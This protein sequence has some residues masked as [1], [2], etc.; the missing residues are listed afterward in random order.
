MEIIRKK[1][2]L[3][4]NK[5]HINSGLPYIPCNKEYTEILSC[6]TEPITIAEWMHDSIFEKEV[7]ESNY[8]NFQCDI[9]EN[10]P[11]FSAITCFTDSLTTVDENE[12][13]YTLYIRSTNLFRRYNQL[14]SIL[15]EGLHLKH[16]KN[17]S[18]KDVGNYTDTYLSNFTYNGVSGDTTYGFLR[19]AVPV[20]IFDKDGEQQFINMGNGVYLGPVVEGSYVI[21]LDNYEEFITLGGKE[22]IDI[23]D[24]LL[25]NQY[26]GTS[27]DDEIDNY[28]APYMSI[29][30]LL[31]SCED[32]LGIMTP[33]RDENEF[34]FS[35]ELSYDVANKYNSDT[36]GGSLYD[37]DRIYNG[38]IEDNINLSWKLRPR[39]INELSALT[40]DV[41]VESQLQ[42][43]RVSKYYVSDDNEI[44]PGL[45]IENTNPFF[46]CTYCAASGE[47]PARWEAVSTGSTGLVC[48][49][50]EDIVWGETGKYQTMTVISSL[51]KYENVPNNSG[52]TF[53]VKYNNSEETP[54]TIPYVVGEV[55]NRGFD[56]ITNSYIGD[57]II[58]ME[59]TDEEIS[60]EYV[61]GAKFTD[62]TYST[63]VNNTGIYYKETY[64]YEKSVSATTILDG[65]ETIYWYNRINFDESTSVVYSED[66]NLN[67]SAVISL[68][69]SLVV[70][71]V[72]KKDGS[73]INTPLIKEEYLMSASMDAITKIDVSIDRGN[74]TAFEKHLILGECNSF[75]DLAN[76]KGNYFN[77]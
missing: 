34:V 68:A 2:S 63:P 17:E 48:A 55:V 62:N 30:I 66:L 50:G 53:L 39:E 7:Y 27:I 4:Q 76:Y 20:D 10:S 12:S 72:W 65:V 44:L 61:I 41:L 54:M 58:S 40:N 36:S 29:P 31:T 37:E 8:G 46:R 49:D 59:E 52:Y 15:R 74:A 57:Y 26:S 25:V 21:V 70:G 56:K 11:I 69:D 13:G 43:L 24:S 9:T 60:F 73:V 35:G 51:L 28:V 42:T 18:C 22:L 33:Y 67:R 3:E 71:D 16:I 75:Q 5:S 77:L 6:S 1:I 47:T 14:L 38:V 64:P 19:E 23:V 32:S 45:F